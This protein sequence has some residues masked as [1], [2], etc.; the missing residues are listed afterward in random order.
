[1]SK[2]DRRPDLIGA[3]RVAPASPLLTFH[4]PTLSLPD[5]AERGACPP[6]GLTPRG[7]ATMLRRRGMGWEGEPSAAASVVRAPHCRKPA[8]HA[9]N[10]T[11]SVRPAV[12]HRRCQAAPPRRLVPR[13]CRCVAVAALI[14]PHSGVGS[15]LV[16]VHLLSLPI[17]IVDCRRSRALSITL[18]VFRRS[19]PDHLRPPV[20]DT[21]YNSAATAI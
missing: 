9:V 5:G 4:F 15:I 1:M 19:T 21:C 12:E 13:S 17:I 14:T 8:S 20:N 16:I 6:S 11:P 3:V 10:A 18:D 2:G 7:I